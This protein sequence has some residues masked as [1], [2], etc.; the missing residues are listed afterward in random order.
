MKMILEALLEISFY[1]TLIAGAVLLFCSLMRKHISPKLQYL[2]WTL[3]LIR[4]CFP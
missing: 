4:L 3:V 2:A 1:A